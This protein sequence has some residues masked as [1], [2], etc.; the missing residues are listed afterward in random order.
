MKSL[1]LLAHVLFFF[2]LSWM[3]IWNWRHLAQ[4]ECREYVRQGFIEH[5]TR[6]FVAHPA[7]VQRSASV[8]DCLIS[9]LLFGPSLVSGFACDQKTL[10]NVFEQ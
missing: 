7:R 5:F 9:R 1:N 3:L 2:R 6:K 4:S 8:V 10:N